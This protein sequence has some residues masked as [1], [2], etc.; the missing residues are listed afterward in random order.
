MD[1]QIQMKESPS[2]E[3]K[4]DVSMILFSLVVA[5][6]GRST[7]LGRLLESLTRQEISPN[8][9]EVIIVDQNDTIDL[10][11]VIDKYRVILSIVHIKS[12]KKGLSFNRN[13]GIRQSRGKYLCFPDDDCTY[14]PDTLAKVLAN[15]GNPGVSTVFGAIRDRVRG[16]NIIRNWPQKKVGLTRRNF[17]FL[18]SSITVFTEN[19]KVLFNETLGAGCYF[20]SY[21]DADFSYRQTRQGKAIYYPD[22]E[23][24]HPEI[25]L[26][27]FSKEKNISYGLGFG[28]FCNIHKKDLFIIWIF[29]AAIGFHL[30]KGVLAILKFDLEQ[31]GKRKDAVWS[32]IKGF[33]QYGRYEKN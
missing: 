11:G 27:E 24:W 28:A 14:Y 32:R 30:A 3:N 8:Q 23:V 10:S 25:G 7:E 31:A 20:G 2:S 16:K 1:S 6:Y 21:E 4:E 18:N 29:L 9:F 22:I 15:F 12:S 5:T 33:Y 17:F 13:I 26:V 19:N